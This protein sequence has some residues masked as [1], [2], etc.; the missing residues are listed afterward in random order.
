M[1]SPTVS[2]VRTFAGST[3]TLRS[4]AFSAGAESRVEPTPVTEHACACHYCGGT[5]PEGR[6]ITFCPFCGLDLTVRHCPAC[7]TPLERT[8]RFCVTCG[9]QSEDGGDQSMQHSEHDTIGDAASGEDNRS[10]A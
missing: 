2:I 9:R 7:S 5:L 10:A 3:L 8:W 1:A 4:S 6:T